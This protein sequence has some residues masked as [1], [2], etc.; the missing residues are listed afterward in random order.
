MYGISEQSKFDL[1]MNS[2][3][4]IS[5]NIQTFKKHNHEVSPHWLINLKSEFKRNNKYG[6][7]LA[8][9]S[10]YFFWVKKI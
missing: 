8:Y 10:G 2:L 9:K 5:R 4:D 7:T 3:N 1:E 6:F